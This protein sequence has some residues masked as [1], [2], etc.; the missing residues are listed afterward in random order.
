MNL[1]IFRTKFNIYGLKC[2]QIIRAVHKLRLQAS[3]REWVIQMSTIL[4]REIPQNSVNVVYE[5]P[6]SQKI[7]NCH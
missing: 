4:Q 7:S 3:G 6:L 1:A 5:W 2:Q